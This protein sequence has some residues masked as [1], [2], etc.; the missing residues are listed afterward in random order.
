MYKTT[1]QI[2]FKFFQTEEDD[3]RRELRFFGSVSVPGLVVTF[4]ILPF[5]YY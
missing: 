4:F 2:D 3:F 1:L 5:R